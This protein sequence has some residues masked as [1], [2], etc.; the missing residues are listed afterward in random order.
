MPSNSINIFC[1]A[2]PAGSRKCLRNLLILKMLCQDNR[3]ASLVFHRHGVIITASEGPFWALR[4]HSAT[5]RQE[6][7]PSQNKFYTE[8]WFRLYCICIRIFGFLADLTFPPSH[9]DQPE[10]RLDRCMSRGADSAGE[11]I[12]R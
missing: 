9:S 4:E 12:A 10:Q 11:K 8:I 6:R 1:P 7:N 5:A 2:L 3:T